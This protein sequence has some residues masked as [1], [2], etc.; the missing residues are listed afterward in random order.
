MA[1]RPEPHCDRALIQRLTVRASTAKVVG[2]LPIRTGCSPEKRRYANAKGEPVSQAASSL[3]IP[4]VVDIIR[5]IIGTSRYAGQSLDPSMVFGHP[6]RR[7]S[8]PPLGVALRYLY[9]EGVIRIGP[10]GGRV[11]ELIRRRPASGQVRIDRHRRRDSIE[12]IRKGCRQSIGTVR[13][14]YGYAGASVCRGWRDCTPLVSES[15]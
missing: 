14:T 15:N 11:Q 10:A 7:Q 12:R 6:E 9:L 8:G 2:Q 1:K 3:P 5:I 4:C 13:M